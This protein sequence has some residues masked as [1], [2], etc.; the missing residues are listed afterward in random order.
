LSAF[1]NYNLINKDNPII[2]PLPKISRIFVDGTNIFYRHAG[3][4]TSPTLLLL[5]GYPSSSFYFRNLIS[6]LS[7]RYYVV[8]PDYPG[9]GFTDVPEARKYKYTFENLTTTVEKF[10]DALH[11]KKF[12]MY[13]YDFGAPIG[14]RLA[15]RRPDA[16]TAII[17]Q[18][19]NAY[20]EGLGERWKVPRE[21]WATNSPELRNAIRAQVMDFERTK[22]QYV[23][24]AKDGGAH[25]EPEGY[26]LDYALLQRPGIADVMVDLFYDYR[27][28]VQLY[29]EFQAYLKQRQPPTLVAWG[30]NDVSFIPAGAEAFRKDVPDAEVHLLEGGHFALAGLEETF[31]DL[32]SDFLARKL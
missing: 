16:I 4:P 7:N 2:M 3:A 31:A 29:S 25:I 17:T 20:D 21:F 15:L 14:L 5:H 19:G 12:A 8:A 30:K 32:I 23:N 1:V 27:T 13:I 26:I 6:L 22:G 18:N 11:I 9:F 10:I 24:G 28:N